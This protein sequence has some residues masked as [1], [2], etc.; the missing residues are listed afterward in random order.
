MPDTPRSRNDAPELRVGARRVRGPGGE[1]GAG[2][3]QPRGLGE[4]VRA[5]R[6][7]ATAT[8]SGRCPPRNARSGS[9]PRERE[10]AGRR[11]RFSSS[12]PKPA[13]P[14]PRAKASRPLPRRARRTRR[15]GPPLPAGRGTKGTPRAP[16][17]S[18][19]R[20][21]RGVLRS[22]GLG[23]GVPGRDP[24]SAVPHRRS[25]DRGRTR[26]SMPAEPGIIRALPTKTR[27]RQL[28]GRWIGPRT[29]ARNKARTSPRSSTCRAVPTPAAY[30]STRSGS[31]GSAIPCG[32]L[33]VPPEGRKRSRPSTCTWT[34]PRTSR[35]PTCPASCR[36]STTTS[37][38]SPSP[39][40]SACCARW[41]S[42]SRRAPAT[43]R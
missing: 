24:A 18:R 16:L 17:P 2:R 20:F 6:R 4:R 23:T 1:D 36:S 43:S 32:S 19:P 38:R 3:P 35:G 5:R 31:R 10:T 28:E 39:P 21:P 30:P 11:K 37:T 33:T 22:P 34:C 42:C 12:D 29:P 26:A 40:S 9:S 13:T 25:D 41:W 8:A 7:P 14:A 15:Q 27:Y